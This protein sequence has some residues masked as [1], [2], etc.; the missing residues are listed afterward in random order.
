MLL[1]VQND[2]LVPPAVFATL[3]Q[4]A[5][6]AFS[7]WHAYR[8][9]PVPALDDVQGLIILGGTMGAHDVAQYPFLQAVK[10]LI[11]TALQRR[12]PL[13]GICLGGQLLALVAGGSVASRTDG[14]RGLLPIRL[15]AGAFD[16]PLFKGLPAEP[17]FFQWHDDSF[18]PPVRAV[19]LA[20]SDGCRHQAFRIGLAWGVQFHPEVDRETVVA[21]SR[22]EEAGAGLVA[23]FTGGESVSL[24]QA[25][26]LLGNFL[27]VVDRTHSVES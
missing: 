9:T 20:G 21:W 16:D 26:I 4:E 7:C 11:D 5:G 10:G 2:P 15:T 25:R 22:G 3:L 27:Q 24:Q 12:I 23:A 13:L 19:P 1:I 8:D 6:V 18:T 17:A 14:E